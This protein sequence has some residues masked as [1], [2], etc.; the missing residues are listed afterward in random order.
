ML[1]SMLL[2]S[3][4]SPDEMNDGEDIGACLWALYKRL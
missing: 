4:Y 1:D 3:S 2:T